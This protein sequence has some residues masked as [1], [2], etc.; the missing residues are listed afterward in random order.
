MPSVAKRNARGRSAHCV[1]LGH[2]ELHNPWR[3]TISYPSRRRI[4]Y[5]VRLR[6]N[7]SYTGDD[8]VVHYQ[9][10]TFSA[11]GEITGCCVAVP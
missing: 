11:P 1:A 6:I 3:C 10:Q 5:T 8:Q 7:G 2:G 4:Q 9:G